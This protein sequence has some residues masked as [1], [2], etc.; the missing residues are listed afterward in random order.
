MT[1][2]GKVDPVV[3]DKDSLVAGREAHDYVDTTK[4]ADEDKGIV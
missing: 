3:Q 2:L 4:Y 1:R